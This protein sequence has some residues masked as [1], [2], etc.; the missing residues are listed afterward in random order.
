MNS[1]QARLVGAGVTLLLALV[2]GAI[3][4]WVAPDGSGDAATTTPTS[5]T[6]VTPTPTESIE[7]TATKPTASRSPSIKPTVKPSE[8]DAIPSDE[9]TVEP[10]LPPKPK[11]TPTSTD[12]PAVGGP[13]LGPGGSGQGVAA[14]PGIN[15]PSSDSDGRADSY[16]DEGDS[17]S[18]AAAAAAFIGV[19]VT[20][21]IMIVIFSMAAR[22]DREDLET[23]LQ[24]DRSSASTGTRAMPTVAPTETRRGRQDRA[25]LVDALIYVRD[26]ATSTAISDRLAAT[27]RSVGVVEESPVGDRFDPARHEAGGSELTTDPGL[28]DTVSGVEVVGY[29]DADGTVLRPPVVTVYRRE[30]Q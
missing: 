3:T 27:L 16:S 4:G 13:A 24:Y 12:A 2:F 21:F 22:R 8:S 23:E 20:G 14:D 6:S 25:T 7:P 10:T 19:L 30:G 1:R 17:F 15:V 18:V 28:I 29:T 26:R 9:P 11:P 5:D